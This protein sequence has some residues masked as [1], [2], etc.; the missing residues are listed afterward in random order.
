MNFLWKSW[1][2]SGKDRKSLFCLL[3]L[4]E[5]WI[6][7]KFRAINIA[8]KYFENFDINTG[9][10]KEDFETITLFQEI[11]QNTT[12]SCESPFDENE[13]FND[14]SRVNF[15]LIKF[16]IQNQYEKYIHNI[17]RILDCVECQKCR[18]YGKLQVFGLGTALKIILAAKQKK[19]FPS[20]KRNEFIVSIHS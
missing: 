12:K 17:S 2:L 14:E 11:L 19:P 9:N 20:I 10:L 7:N 5:V 6:P 4:T 13:I 16:Q 18:L 15:F 3:F 1:K 8:S